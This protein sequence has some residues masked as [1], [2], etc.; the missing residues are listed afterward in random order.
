MT[1]IYCSTRPEG[2]SRVGATTTITIQIDQ[3]PHVP[4]RRHVH[5][6]STDQAVQDW[7]DTQKDHSASVRR[8]I[9]DEIATN[10]L[11]DRMHR[12]KF[13]SNPPATGAVPAASAA[14]PAPAPAAAVPAGP[15]VW[16][17]PGLDP[18]DAEIVRLRAEIARLEAIVEPFGP[19]ISGLAKGD[20]LI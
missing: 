13:G 16:G 4:V 19:F 9:H 14:A 20:V 12:A 2:K 8:L 5:I 7:F 11:V 18:R 3:T 17:V 6:P 1:S 15:A 10:G